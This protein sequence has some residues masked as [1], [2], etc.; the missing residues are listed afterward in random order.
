M[1]CRLNRWRRPRRCLLRWPLIRPGC[2]PSRLQHSGGRSRN[3]RKQAEKRRPRPASWSGR[4]R[5]RMLQTVEVRA[6]RVA[7]VASEGPASPGAA[8]PS[9]AQAQEGASAPL[10][11]QAPKSAANAFQVLGGYPLPALLQ[12]PVQGRPAQGCPVRKAESR[13]AAPRRRE[14]PLRFE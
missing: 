3:Q 6:Q 12:P 5:P 9:G 8:A 2:R 7:G 1:D 13:W 4:E 10:L 11:P 14:L